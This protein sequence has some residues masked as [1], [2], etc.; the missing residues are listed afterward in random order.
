MNAQPWIRVPNLRKDVLK[1]LLNVALRARSDS[2][3]AKLM[4][5]DII[6]LF[7]GGK[8][9]ETIMLNQVCD[10]SDKRLPFK[11]KTLTLAKTEESLKQRRTRDRKGACNVLERL[12]LVR[13]KNTKLFPVDYNNRVG[14]LNG[15]NTTNL[16]TPV[17]VPARNDEETWC[18]K[19]VLKKKVFEGGNRIA[20]G[21]SANSGSESESDVDPTTVPWTKPEVN[22]PVFF[23][24]K[25]PTMARE[26]RSQCE[27]SNTLD[28]T[29]G[30]ATL[31][32]DHVI[33][34]GCYAGICFNSEHK[35]LLMTYIHEQTWKE[36][37]KEGSKI[38]E[39][40]MVNPINNK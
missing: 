19:A 27:I 9:L 1:R 36:C 40:A 12:I 10:D 13:T 2:G 17:V 24:A 33:W 16:I 4:D 23:H 31:A 28:L 25:G 11:K 26:A 21:A 35:K 6:H 39:P 20:A 38:Y 29:A 37:L 18:L 5:G 3:V 32:M 14:D 7:D 34:G 8:N 15:T 30:E 22:Q